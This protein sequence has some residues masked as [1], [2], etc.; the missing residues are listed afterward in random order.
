MF[1]GIIEHLGSADRVEHG[2]DGSR[3]TVLIP[4]VDD[5]REGESIAVQGVCLTA[6]TVGAGVFAADVS[7]ET[8][9]RTALGDLRVGDRLHLERSLRVGDRLGGHFVQGHVDEVGVIRGVTRE[10]EGV[11]LDVAVSPGARRFLVEKGSIALD[12]VSLTIAALL[13]EGARIALIPYTLASTTL[14]G[15]T[16]GARVNVEFDMLAKYVARLLEPDA[17]GGVDGSAIDESFLQRH[18]YAQ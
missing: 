13:S 12:G 5:L 1:T 14:G 15:K 3:V 11:L 18:G 17:A 8:L 16:V 4:G 7:A 6:A 2:Q 10:G 9:R